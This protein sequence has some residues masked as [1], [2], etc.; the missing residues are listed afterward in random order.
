MLWFEVKGG[1]E[2]GKQ[3]MNTVKLWSLAENLG[4][5]DPW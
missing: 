4:S 3:L 5:V 2:A 1:V